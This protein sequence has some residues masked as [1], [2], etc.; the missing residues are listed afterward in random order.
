MRALVVA[1][2]PFFSPR[3]TPLSVYYRTVVM[4]ELGVDIDLLT[5]GQ[6]EDVEIPGVRILRIPAFGWLGPVPVGPSLLK[7]FLDLFVVARTF[8]LLLRHRYDFVHAHE[9]SVF[10]CRFLKPVSRAKLV[11]DMHSSLPQQLTNFAFTR[12][13]L[14][15]GLFERLEDSSLRAADAV[16]TISPA[17]A[18]Y[19]R[20]RMPDPGRH[21]L[22]ENSLIDEVRLKSPAA[23]TQNARAWLGRISSD[24]IVVGYAGTFESYQGLE[25]LVDAF[26]L[27][28]QASPD[29][30]LL[31]IGGSPAQV[32]EL[33]SRAQRQGLGEESLFTGTLP[34]PEA[35][36]LLERADV[37]T[38]PRRTGT[39]TP[40]KI[41]SYLA[42]GK[43]FVATRIPAH[44]QLLTEEVCFLADPEPTALADAIL[45]AMSSERRQSTVDAARSFYDQRYS[46]QAYLGKMRGLLEV[47]T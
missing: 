43:P 13:R 29:A 1:P 45:E 2:Q 32:E 10:F 33:E 4:A 37:L 18:D 42:S 20:D 12:S 36:R 46:R 40:L 19:A 7:L 11:Y 26:A 44:T 28:R 41:Y 3:G 6:G 23:A 31:M 21:F 24:R 25:L 8:A 22:I 39:N 9:E 35:R 30:F 17:L 14:L 5:Y 16:I 15:I 47:L 38:S 27:V 34:Q